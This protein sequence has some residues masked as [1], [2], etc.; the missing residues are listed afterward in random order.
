[1]NFEETNR[2]LFGL[3]HETLTLKLGLRNT[4]L[5]LESLGN[6]HKSFASLQIAGTNGKGSTAVV[7]DSICR[8]AGIN[9]GL[10]TSP[11][12]I[13]VTERIRI[14]GNEISQDSFAEYASEVRVAAESLVNRR[15][16]DAL[17]T[18][19]EHITAISL[20]AFKNAGIT[21]AILETGLGGRLDATTVAG[22]EIVAI[23]PLALD[24]QE[25][26][27]E[28]LEEIAGEKA[29]IIRRGVTAIIAAQPPPALDVILRRCAECDVQPSVDE[30][31]SVIENATTDGRFRVTFE[32]KQGQYENV[33][34][35][36]RGRHQI[37]NVA[38][39]I[40]LAESL[41]RQGFEI[42]TQSIVRGIET[43]RH[44]GRLEL[45]EG[46][47]SLLLDGA[48]NPSGAQALREF[49]DEFV[50][51]PLTLVFGAMRDKKLD[52][53]AAILFPAARH[54]VLTEPNNLRAARVADLH[55][56]AATIGDQKNS[57]AAPSV[58]EALRQAKNVTP[59]DGL[60]CITGS[61]Y[62][63]GEVKAILNST[64]LSK[65]A[66]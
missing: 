13:S 39:A 47:P 65:V 54:L 61:L 44:P 43:A 3:G 53:I 19:F 42:P 35:G 45:V 38:V 15:K 40:R 50:H 48:H 6:P 18:F 33:L 12:L 4:K 60:I 27:G 62:L 30:C 23:T 57:L 8:D 2:Y 55:R 7:L 10:F 66:S 20:L 64:L 24:H 58:S 29:A 41:R 25:H 56:L 59:H 36:L 21:L 37:V 46:Q 5:L 26:L 17:P 11:H 16:L 49:L 51:V 52:E 28:T 63:V 34:L 32:T 9:T 14:D 1:M 31:R 22:A